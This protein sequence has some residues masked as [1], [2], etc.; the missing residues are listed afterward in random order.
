[1]RRGW[2]VLAI[3]IIALCI[4]GTMDYNDATGVSQCGR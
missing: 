1:M 3:T 4:A 2:I